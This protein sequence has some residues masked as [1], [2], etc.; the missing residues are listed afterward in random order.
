M[1]SNLE[2]YLIYTDNF[3]IR[4]WLVTFVLVMSTFLVKLAV[5][6]YYI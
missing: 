1:N 5:E 4:F 2:S 6:A 3:N